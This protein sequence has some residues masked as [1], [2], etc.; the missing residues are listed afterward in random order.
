[1]KQKKTSEMKRIKKTGKKVSFFF[2]FI[3]LKLSAVL[4]L[5]KKVSFFFAVRFGSVE[6]GCIFAPH[7]S[8]KDMVW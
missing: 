5:G 6:N 7:Y 8:S 3:V 1:M 4:V 2:G